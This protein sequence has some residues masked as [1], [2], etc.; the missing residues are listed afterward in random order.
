MQAPPVNL[1]H[2]LKTFKFSDG[3][4]PNL[5][6]VKNVDVSSTFIEIIFRSGLTL[7]SSWDCFCHEDKKQTWSWDMI[8]EWPKLTQSKINPPTWQI[9]NQPNNQPTKIINQ[10]KLINQSNWSTNQN[11]QPT[12]QII[13]QPKWSTNQNDQPTKMINQPKL[14]TN[15]NNQPTKIINQP[16]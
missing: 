1:V 16:N 5:C 13:H 8:L 2:I 7:V 15:Q 4:G 9:I 10:I 14:S 12:W 6:R 3:D 11:S